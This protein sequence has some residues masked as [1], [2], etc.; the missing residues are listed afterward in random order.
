M[1]TYVFDPAWQK[2]RDRLGALESLFDGSSRRLLGALG[3]REGWR[4]L[5]VGCGAGGIARWLADQV[6]SAGHVLATDL[7]T[8]FLTGHGPANLEVLTHDVV[9]DR[10]DDAAF[11]LVHARAVLEHI[12]ARRDV[13]PR[14]VSALKPG[15]WLLVE[16]VDFGG[17]TA[18]ALA[19]Y[20][21]PSQVAAT[22]ERIYL[23]AAA[24]FAAV[25]ADAS[26]GRQLPTALADAG[27]VKVGAEVHTSVVNG[28]DERWTRGTVEQLADRLVSTGLTSRADVE[29]FLATT[30]QPST[31]YVPPLMVSAWGQRPRV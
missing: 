12:P 16:D 13:L 31:S 11:D 8:R 21:S 29:L 30:A 22:T 7:D 26:Y 14:L 3:L 10:L 6:G 27:L 4:C 18:S 2:E 9:T 19:Q 17:P 25:G 20:F 24:L 1:S 23:A 5:E 28:G 15:G